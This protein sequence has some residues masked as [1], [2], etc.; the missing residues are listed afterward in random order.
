VAAVEGRY[1]IPWEMGFA[2]VHRV[3]IVVQEEKSEQSRAFDDRHAMFG[4][5]IGPMLR[6]G[7]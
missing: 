2:V 6:E 1:P 7:A 3:Q 5:R 4:I